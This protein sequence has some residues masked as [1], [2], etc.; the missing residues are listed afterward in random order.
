MALSLK[1]I[2]NA[3]TRS[4]KGRIVKCYPYDAK[5][6]ILGPI[7]MFLAVFSSTANCGPN[8]VPVEPNRVAEIAPE[9]DIAVTINGVD[10]TES[11]VDAEV[12]Q[13][14]KRMR[15]PSGM[16]PQ[17]LEQYKKELRQPALEELITRMLLDEKIKAEVVVTE[18]EVI[19]YLEGAGSAQKPPLSLEDIK[20]RIRASGQ[21]FD[22]VKQNIRRRLGYQR[23]MEAQWA[24]RINITED[25]ARKYYN[26]NPRQFRAPEQV[27]ASHILIKPD[28]SDPNADPNET[29]AKAKAKAHE[30]LKKIQNADDDFATLAKVN[31]ACPSA[32]RGGDLGLKPRGTWVKP[33]EE[34]AF[35]LKVGQV[36]DVVETQFGYHIIKLTGRKEPTITMFEEAR[37]GIINVLTRKKRD[38]ITKEYIELLKAKANIVYPPGKE[39]KATIPIVRPARPT[40]DDSN[41]TAINVVSYKPQDTNAVE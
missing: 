7:V 31:S 30:L 5:F 26:E 24:G 3:L 20:E 16:P 39:P 1:L 29:K 10:I 17:F 35:K 27:K 19:A 41:A 11:D 8:T 6:E 23:L 25:E 21:D 33:F 9:T 22:D 38:E 15:I 36:S 40:P 32:A 37:D 12:A 18:E 4:R 2:L 14:L 13:R 34:A 28:T